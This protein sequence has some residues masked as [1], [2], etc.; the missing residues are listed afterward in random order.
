MSK[1]HAGVIISS[2][3]G[4][5][6]NKGKEG[7]KALGNEQGLRCH[8]LEACKTLSLGCLW[9]SFLLVSKSVGMLTVDCDALQL[10]EGTFKSQWQVKVKA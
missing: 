3:L 5:L 1:I 4:L 8:K 2:V 7:D 9:H 10:V 6:Q